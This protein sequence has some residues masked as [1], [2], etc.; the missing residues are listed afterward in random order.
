MKSEFEDIARSSP[1]LRS[2]PSQI[3]DS[4][5]TAATVHDYD[6]GATIFLQGERASTIYIVAGGWVKL[7]R[8]SPNGSEVVVAILTM[9]AS[10]GE[11]V[12]FRSDNYPVTAEAA[13]DCTLISI[14]ADTI[15][16]LIRK[17]PEIAISI[18][19][20][21]FVHLHRLVAQIEQLKARTGAQRLAEF[22]LEL[23]PC[24]DGPCEVVLPYDKALIAGRLGLKP[25]S[26]SRAFAKLRDYGVTIKL[27]H[28]IIGD[29]QKLRDLADEDPGL[30]WTKG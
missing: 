22:L 18:L 29:V 13:T 14:P 28:A 3:V 4:V 16:S 27:N 7:Y 20:A 11:A 25:E 19:S 12:A 23:A 9:G 24:S 8:I 15:L 26:L 5:L 30:A 17:S 2:I 21:A 10:F 6:R 1:L